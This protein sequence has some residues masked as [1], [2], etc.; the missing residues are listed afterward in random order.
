MGVA[1]DVID[2]YLNG[3][4]TGSSPGASIHHLLLAV[5][6]RS[7]LGL[8]S[9][10]VEVFMYAI[11]PVGPAGF[12]AEGYVAQQVARAVEEH[13]GQRRVV[14]FAGLA[15]ETFALTV[16]DEAGLREARRLQSQGRLQEHPDAAE[17]TVLY[18]AVRDGRRWLGRRLLTG[19]RAGEVLGPT[20]RVGGL[21]ADE[22]RLHQRLIREAVAG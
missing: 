19:R 20:L 17:A 16:S 3:L 14:A 2:G 4:L 5:E 21:G 15:M 13:R 12:D 6:G 18:A 10:D 11:A 8:P 22:R 9:G 1:D 7:P